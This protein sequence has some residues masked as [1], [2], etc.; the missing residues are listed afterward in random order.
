MYRLYIMYIM[1]VLICIIHHEGRTAMTI[2]FLHRN[3]DNKKNVLISFELRTA[4]S[5]FSFKK[6]FSLL[7]TARRVCRQSKVPLQN[8]ALAKHRLSGWTFSDVRCLTILTLSYAARCCI[9]LKY[10]L[11]HL[12]FSVFLEVVCGPMLN[13]F[14]LQ[15][16]TNICKNTSSGSCG[17]NVFVSHTGLPHCLDSRWHLKSLRK[18]CDFQKKLFVV[19]P[20]FHQNNKIVSWGRFLR[21][22]E[23]T[24]Q[25]K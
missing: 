15:S 11:S 12:R 6:G 19:G 9:K 10:P 14:I 22:F 24:C 5:F 17:A 25:M 2:D 7:L 21:D 3:C 20:L 8:A 23:R 18:L 1:P 16:L 13:R 4:V